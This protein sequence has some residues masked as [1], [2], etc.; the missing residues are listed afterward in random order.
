MIPEPIAHALT[1]D[2]EDYFQV[3]NL[4]AH[5]PPESWDR[6]PLRCPAA[7]RRLLDLLD[8]H[9]TKA[10][11]FVLGWIA[12]RVPDLVREIAARGHEV[13]S[14]GYDHRC[15]PE[16]GEVGFR[17]ELA[18]TN[19]ILEPLVGRPIQ[20]FRACTWSISLKTPWALPALVEA[21]FTRD[22]SIHP[23]RHPDYGI[24]DAPLT[25]HIL[26]PLPGREL[27]EL[28]PLVTSFLGRRLPLGGGGYLR[29]FPVRWISSALRRREARSIPSCLYL[30]P[31]EVD[32]DQPRYPVRGL[33]GFRHYVNLKRTEAKLTRLLERHRF[34]TLHEVERHYRQVQRRL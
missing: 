1:I 24:A 27:F 22:S 16:L 9:T 26:E 25:P 28:P 33:R 4:R 15:L 13:G 34:T 30:H 3:L 11:F 2:V 8:R 18:R 6:I 12:E 10:T 23:V 17:A 32:P 31:W 21:G 19:A 5:C 29:L 7:T 14:H 20:A